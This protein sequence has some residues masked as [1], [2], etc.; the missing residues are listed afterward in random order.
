MLFIVYVPHV[1]LLF[2]CPFIFLAYVKVSREVL[3]LVF[4]CNT[5]LL[6]FLIDYIFKPEEYIAV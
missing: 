2:A 5:F 3:A 4:F 1:Q 6:N